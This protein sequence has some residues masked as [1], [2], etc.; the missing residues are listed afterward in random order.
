M[1]VVCC[2]AK[3]E[4]PYIDEWI[5]YNLKLG[6]E[7]IYIYDNSDN[8]SLAPLGQTDKVHVVPFPGP[9][10]QMA[11]YN[12]FL[13]T[14]GREHTWCAFID[15]DEFIVLRCH[16]SIQDM[17][18]AHCKNGSLGLN[19]ILFGSS[20][21]KE[22][23]PEPV[24]E[25]FQM[26]QRGLNAHIKSIVKIEDTMTMDHPHFPCLKGGHQQ[27]DTNGRA[28]SGPFNERGTEDVACIH[29]YFLKSKREFRE[30]VARGR[31]DIS[32]KRAFEE[33]FSRHDLNEVHDSRAWDFYRS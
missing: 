6:F 5:A 17:L 2:I 9:T 13:R 19:W 26:R 30:K 27:L 31:A 24:T 11:A 23:R 29:H 3:N 12:H 20:G 28:F 7:R 14:Y 16:A 15:V 21:K 25:R 22:Y 10:K 1:A 4:E 18:N 8:H 32:I 33:D